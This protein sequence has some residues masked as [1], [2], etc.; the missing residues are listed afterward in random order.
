MVRNPLSL[1]RLIYL[2]GQ[3]AVIYRALKPNPTHMPDAGKHR[4]FSYGRAYGA[5]TSG[6]YG[7]RARLAGVHGVTLMAP[8]QQLRVV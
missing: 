7:N 5:T 6:H 2:D 1:K 8:R 4:T 3:Q